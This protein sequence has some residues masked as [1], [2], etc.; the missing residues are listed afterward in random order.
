MSAPPIPA[1]PHRFTPTDA[2]AIDVLD[3]LAI[4]GPVVGF[5]DLARVCRSRP[6]LVRQALDLLADLGRVTC[7]P[8]GG[9][10]LAADAA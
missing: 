3:A 5:E 6:V 10:S 8:N 4:L 2:L 1:A 7:T 9:Y